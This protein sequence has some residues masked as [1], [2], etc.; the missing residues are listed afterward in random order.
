MYIYVYIYIYIY[1]YTK[2]TDKTTIYVIG[3]LTSRLDQRSTWP[4]SSVALALLACGCDCH[5]RDR[6]P[7][8][9]PKKSRRPVCSLDF[10]RNCSSSFSLELDLD[11]ALDPSTDF[12]D[13][14]ASANVNEIS[15]SAMAP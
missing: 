4:Q 14:L 15:E 2:T 3:L 1:I 5:Q 6:R 10:C 9:W 12:C 8:Y 11:L 13:T 7:R